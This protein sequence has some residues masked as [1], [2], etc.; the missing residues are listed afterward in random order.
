MA[1]L[2]IRPVA[3]ENE[4][5]VSYLIRVADANGFRNLGYMLNYAGLQWKNNRAPVFNILSGQFD[6]NPLL[7]E[8]KL[9]S[10]NS[11]TEPVY[12]AFIRAIDTPYLFVKFPKVCP[13]CI[14]EVGYCRYEWSF[15][16]CIVCTKHKR[17]LV[18]IQAGAGKRLSWYRKSLDKYDDGSALYSPRYP[19][20]PSTIQLSLYLERL[21]MG[22]TAGLS[23]PTIL[24]DLDMRES[25][26]LIHLL[27][28]Y[29]ARIV[30][31]SFAPASMTNADL[32]Q[33]YNT[34]W[35]SLASWPNSFYELLG[36]YTDRPM[37]GRGIA[38]LNKH[39]RDLYDRLCRQQGNR[40]IARIKAEFDRYVDVYWPGVLDTDRISRI[41]IANP[42]RSVISKKAAAKILGCRPERI[43]RL[44]VQ[45]ELSPVVFKGGSHLRREQVEAL[46]NLIR[47]NW[48]VDRACAALQLTRYKVKLLLDA[49]LLVSIQRPSSLNRDWIIDREKCEGVF[50]KI[51]VKALAGQSMSDAVSLVGLQSRGY[52]IVEVVSGMLSGSLDYWFQADAEH[53]LSFKQFVAFRVNSEKE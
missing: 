8:L 29:Q 38:G 1:K 52:S 18:D 20:I 23:M 26:S 9:P 50:K 46:A 43:D 34:V 19:C 51:R 40:G 12:R 15:L 49:G 6:I 7:G 22:R 17:M 37:S 14:N 11:K 10:V 30:G 27:A 36:Q 39:F 32:G 47:T 42:L 13:D 45:G 44:I 41:H 25:L 53:P 33:H 5:V 35:N 16:L 2:L 48:S 24:S 21:L 28:H 31:G 4:C 3:H